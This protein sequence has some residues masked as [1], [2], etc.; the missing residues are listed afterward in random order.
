MGLTMK[1]Y[2]LAFAASA[3]EDWGRCDS[4]KEVIERRAD[5]HTLLSGHSRQPAT[6]ESTLS[7]PKSTCSRLPS[8]RSMTALIV[9]STILPRCMLTLTRSPTP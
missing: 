3:Q 8:V 2:A 9:A 6:N 5:Q 7:F 1:R 4:D